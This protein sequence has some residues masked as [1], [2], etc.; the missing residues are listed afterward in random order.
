[1]K[2][3]SKILKNSHELA[4]IIASNEGLK[5]SEALGKAMKIVW[6]DAKIMATV[7]QVLTAEDIR[8]IKIRGLVDKKLKQV[9]FTSFDEKQIKR[10][11]QFA[12]KSWPM[13]NGGKQ[14]FFSMSFYNSIS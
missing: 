2:T 1:M 10:V 12:F 13:H 8:L 4:R 7:K 11:E 6:C 14:M 5:Y 3:K 9:Y